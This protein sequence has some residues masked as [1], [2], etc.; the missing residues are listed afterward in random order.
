MYVISIPLLTD[1]VPANTGFSANLSI[2][3]MNLQQK[4]HNF[5]TGEKLDWFYLF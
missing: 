5:T 1:T 3:K 2:S 4:V